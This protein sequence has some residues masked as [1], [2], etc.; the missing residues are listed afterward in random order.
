MREI[1]FRVWN[2]AYKEMLEYPIY[3]LDGEGLK[4][5]DFSELMQ[6]T[7]LKDKNEKEI[8]EGD[9]IRVH[10]GKWVEYEEEWGGDDV[11]TKEIVKRE[12]KDFIGVV[13]WRTVGGIGFVV[14]ELN[15]QWFGFNKS[16]TNKGT[17]V[18]GNIYENP[19]LNERL[20]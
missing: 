11:Y 16:K 9:I 13:R 8:Y 5:D 2:K 4:G 7:G 19:E 1:K 3:E 14:K 12:E 20:I 18:I 6:Y 17:E 10:F 15:N